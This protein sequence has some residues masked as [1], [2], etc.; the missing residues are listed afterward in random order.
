M[1]KNS[2]KTAI[3]LIELI[4]ALMLL[5]IVLLGIFAISN[6][7]S[8]NNQDYGQRYLVRSETQT[9]LNNIL[10]AASLAVGSGLCISAAGTS[11]PPCNSPYVADQGI[12]TGLNVGGGYQTFCIH[13]NPTSL[14]GGD[15]WVCYTFVPT[16]PTGPYIYYCNVPYN[17]NDPSGNR[18]AA[19]TCSSPELVAGTAY[20]ISNPSPPSF[21]ANPLTNQL[22]FTITIQ[23]CLNDLNPPGTCSPSGTSIDPVNN[24]EV[25]VT[26]SVSPQQEGTG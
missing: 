15:T 25:T 26:G 14:L 17:L 7:L 10:N 18:G 11:A 8:N 12:L 2:S 20:S 16:S 19:G 3:T 23:N 13:Q 9:T 22:Q 21:V 6:V 1:K 4:F 24:P 5:S